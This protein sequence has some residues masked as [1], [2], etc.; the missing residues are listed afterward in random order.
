[1]AAILMIC[2]VTFVFCTGIKG[3]MQDRLLALIRPRGTAVATV[4]GHSVTRED[5]QK[6][7]MQRNLAD[8][9]MRRC[10][11][12][13]FKTLQEKIFELS[14]DT[15]NDGPNRAQQ[16]VILDNMRT[17]LAQRKSRPRY[18]ESG[19]KFDDL[20][21]FKL[22]QAQADKMEIQLEPEDVKYL[23][24]VEF[25]NREVRL[26]DDQ[27]FFQ[28]Q[29]E[30]QRNHPDVNNAYVLRAIGEEFRVQMAQLAVMKAQPASFFFRCRK[31]KGCRRP[32]S[33][34]QMC[35][36]RFARRQPWTPSGM[37][38]RKDAPNS[39]SS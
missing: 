11:D 9:I 15:K 13:A 33:P 26:L 6:L 20:L 36:T 31:M 19:T 5:L 12:H 3:D 22:W 17:S 32:N 23:V 25:Y 16:M 4:G 38:S 7:K 1:M 14:K 29:R 10:A 35:P 24:N 27:A 8:E 39:T 34:S 18:F 28:V 37:N 21:E 30:S 2:M